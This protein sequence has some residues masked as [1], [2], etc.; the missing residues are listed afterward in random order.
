MATETPTRPRRILI[1]DDNE[2][3]HDDFR[4]IFRR[5]G[6]EADMDID[7]FAAELLGTELATNPDEQVNIRLETVSCGEDAI[8][9]VEDSLDTGDSFDLAFV[10]MRMPGGWDGLETITRLWQVAPDLQIVICTAYS[11]RSWS[12]IFDRLG[13]RDNVL[14]LKKPFEAIEVKQLAMSLCEKRQLQQ[15]VTASMHRLEEIV[16][17]RTRQL[18]K[19][20]REAHEQLAARSSELTAIRSNVHSALL[21]VR[22][23]LQQGLDQAQKNELEFVRIK[24]VEKATEDLDAAVQIVQHDA[25]TSEVTNTEF[26]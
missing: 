4:K 1:V 19:S 15:E 11:D 7:A 26:A 25:Q 9:I 13:I 14:I 3:I 2:A 6:S 23:G 5:P 22:Q 20:L 16:Y 17:A 12:E 24:A 8:E 10:D 18:T 21:Q